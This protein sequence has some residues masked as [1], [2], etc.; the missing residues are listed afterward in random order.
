MS[1]SRLRVLWLHKTR[2]SFIHLGH[3]SNVQVDNG[4]G[5]TIFP[6]FQ[7]YAMIPRESRFEMI[8]LLS[9]HASNESTIYIQVCYTTECLVFYHS[10]SEIT[11]FVA[12]L[13]ACPMSSD[14]RST[15]QWT[16]LSKAPAI[17]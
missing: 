3:F 9:S 14:S 6:F 11:A 16:A 2:R 12:E 7:F 5:V 13:F 15:L 8:E 1:F 17:D 10:E 4:G